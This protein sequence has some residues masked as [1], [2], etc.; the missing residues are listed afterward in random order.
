MVRILFLE[1]LLK[2]IEELNKWTL[3]PFE[4]SE[5]YLCGK[6]EG[7]REAAAIAGKWRVK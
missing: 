6:K 3:T 2:E 1:G 4:K 7:F 5:V